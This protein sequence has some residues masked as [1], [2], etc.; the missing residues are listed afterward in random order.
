M[1]EIYKS[2]YFFIPLIL[3]QYDFK[4]IH[5]NKN[6]HEDTITENSMNNLTQTF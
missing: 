2:N 4:I 3:Q 1:E 5:S 6:K